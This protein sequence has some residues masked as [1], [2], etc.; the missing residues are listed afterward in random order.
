MFAL[1]LSPNKGKKLPPPPTS[2]ILGSHASA[3]FTVIFAILL[4]GHSRSFNG[5]GCK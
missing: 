2:Q 3:V 1:S 5:H 4:N